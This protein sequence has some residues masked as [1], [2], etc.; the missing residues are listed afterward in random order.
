MLLVTRDAIPPPTA[1]EILRLGATEVV[2]L[3]GTGVVSQ[4]V[5]EQLADTF[6]VTVRRLWGL[7][8]F[9]TA[10]AISKDSYPAGATLVYV[11]N[12]LNFPDALAGGPAAAQAGAPLLLV[13]PDALPEATADELKRLR[14]EQIRI[15]GGSGVVSEQVAKELT[16]YASSVDRLWG[17]DRFATAAVIAEDTFPL[18]ANTVYVAY[19]LN[20]PDALAGGP[21]AAQAGAPLLLV[22]TD[23]IPQPTATEIRRLG[24]VEVVILGG[25]G[26]VSAGVRDQLIVLR[27]PLTGGCLP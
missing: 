3:G 5:A 21:A 27:C 15:L 7:D 13:L 23:A 25:T 2:I 9:A 1:A 4:T 8:R 18:G 11:A 24:A 26:V 17:P 14:P 12:G 20:F 19:G 22:T 10:A 16:S 6:D